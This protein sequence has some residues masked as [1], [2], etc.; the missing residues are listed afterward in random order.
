MNFLRDSW[1]MCWVVGIAELVVCALAYVSGNLFLAV[2]TGIGGFGTIGLTWTVKGFFQIVYTLAI[3]A[4]MITVAYLRY[5]G[6][7]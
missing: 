1:V 7:F 5:T 6:Q 3:A 4:L 2:L